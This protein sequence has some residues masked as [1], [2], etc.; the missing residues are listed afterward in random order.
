MLVSLFP[1]ILAMK[2]KNI[3]YHR[4][5]SIEEVNPEDNENKNNCV[6]Q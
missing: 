2:G 5:A 1:G 4:E 3:H 6:Q